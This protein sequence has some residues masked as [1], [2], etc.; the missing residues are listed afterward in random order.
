LSGVQGSKGA[1]HSFVWPRSLALAYPSHPSH[2]VQGHNDPSR[3]EVQSSLFH[4]SL[5]CSPFQ[6]L[7]QP[8]VT[9]AFCPLPFRW[10]SS[11]RQ[12]F[13]LPLLPAP[14]APL[15]SPAGQ[16]PRHIASR[17]ALRAPRARSLR[18]LAPY[19]AAQLRPPPKPNPFFRQQ[20]QRRRQ[21]RAGLE[22]P[23][24]GVAEPLR[25][26]LQVFAARLGGSPCFRT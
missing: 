5:Q 19:A 21:N 8:L 26:S 17:F 6:P 20:T 25:F 11:P 24:T 22:L 4:I 9:F 12:R 2:Q 14:P 1:H 18:S 15:G 13:R 7:P 16:P 23:V 10:F 3:F